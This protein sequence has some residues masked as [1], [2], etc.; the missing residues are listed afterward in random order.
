MIYLIVL[1]AYLVL[2][3]KENVLC[4]VYFLFW[5][6]VSSFKWYIDGFISLCLLMTDLLELHTEASFV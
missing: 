4:V 3:V 2:V 1:P 6:L 5:F